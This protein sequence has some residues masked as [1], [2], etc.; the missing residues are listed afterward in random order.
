LPL[1]SFR[2]D[3]FP[4]QLNTLHFQ[5]NGHCW[6]IS[7]P[8]YSLPS[9]SMA[10]PFN[11]SPFSAAAAHLPSAQFRISSSRSYAFPIPIGSSRGGAHPLLLVSTHRL[12]LSLRL[13]A[14]PKRCKSGRSFAISI[15]IDPGPL[16]AVSHRGNTWHIPC[17]SVHFL[18]S[19]VRSH[20][21]P[22]A[23]DLPKAMRCRSGMEISV[24]GLFQNL[25]IEAALS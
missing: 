24:L 12:S 14:S 22:S 11:S 23:A 9:R 10:R 15:L 4:L 5:Y 18:R 13:H 21:L 20:P 1:I 25:V 19:S 16:L 6:S 2:F 3:A 7:L 8:V 17:R